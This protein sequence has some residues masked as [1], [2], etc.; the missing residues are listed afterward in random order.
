MTEVLENLLRIAQE[1]SVLIMEVYESPFTVDYKAPRDPVTAADRKANRLIC[2]RLSKLYP[3][4]PVVAEESD[5]Q[6]FVGFRNSERIFFVDPVD[7]TAEFIDK[8]G[9]FVVMIGLVEGERATA[10]V[11][12][13]PAQRR[14]F[15][16]QVGIGAQRIEPDGTRTPIC[17]SAVSQLSEAGVVAS[18]SHRSVELAEALNKLGPKRVVS[19]GSAG[20][21]GAAIATGEAD[22]YVAP[23]QA[24]KRWDACAPD[25]LVT[26][27][28]G[29]FTDLFGKPVDYRGEGLA[30]DKGL[31][32]CNA[33][34]HEHIVA[35]LS[36]RAPN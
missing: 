16:G 22:A 28:G 21:K 34:L 18:R 36:S 4:I 12:L 11:V 27:A 26:A 6:S 31:V 3:D 8:N 33:L 32:A 9:E 29:R 13:A 17:T 1:A 20:L 25:A 14:A 2:E 19:L 7:G 15:I 30:N 5:A 10:G 35:L 23:T 24:G